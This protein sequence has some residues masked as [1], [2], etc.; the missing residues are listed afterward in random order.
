MGM[1]NRAEDKGVRKI[2]AGRDAAQVGRTFVAENG[3]WF[4]GLCCGNIWIG[5]MNGAHALE[6]TNAWHA[7]AS[8]TMVCT[9]MV[10]ACWGWRHPERVQA[11]YMPDWPIAAL[12]ALFT[13]PA[14]GMLVPSDSV[15]AAAAASTVM[16]EIGMAWLF[17]R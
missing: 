1:T 15:A 7:L 3:L 14:V 10:A 4:L 13:L 5:W 9:L 12:M 6:P 11:A 17:V 16:T 2:A 8:A